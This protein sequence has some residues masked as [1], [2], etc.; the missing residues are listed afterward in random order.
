MGCGTNFT[1]IMEP[2][3]SQPAATWYGNQFPGQQSYQ[4]WPM[5][6]QQPGLG[7]QNAQ[8]S[9]SLSPV[10]NSSGDNAVA[11][12]STEISKLLTEFEKH[13]KYKKVS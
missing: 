11:P 10:K 1:W 5:Y 2:A 7:V 9:N 4:E 6:D 3:Q 12:I 8:N 13:L